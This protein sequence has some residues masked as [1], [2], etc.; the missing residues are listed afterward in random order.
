MMGHVQK[1]AASQVYVTLACV[2]EEKIVRM[3]RN[4]NSWFL[5]KKSVMR[6]AASELAI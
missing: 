1:I 3:S 6:E 2:S 4:A 5:R